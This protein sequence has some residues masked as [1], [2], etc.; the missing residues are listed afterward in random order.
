ME[1][2]DLAPCSSGSHVTRIYSRVFVHSTLCKHDM[3]I[4]NANFFG[5]MEYSRSA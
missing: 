2:Q 5:K 4:K 1:C 3:S